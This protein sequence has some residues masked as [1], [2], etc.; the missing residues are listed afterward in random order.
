LDYID[1]YNNRIF[2]IKPKDFVGE[3]EV[4]NNINRIC[5]T[6]ANKEDTII[7]YVK[8]TE[9]MRI[10][11]DFEKVYFNLELIKNFRYQLIQNHKQ[12]YQKEKEE[13]VL[14]KS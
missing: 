14:M 13:E 7:Y 3:I 10:I 5:F 11:N 12:K 2:S 4:I 9:F 1:K 8:K 6:R